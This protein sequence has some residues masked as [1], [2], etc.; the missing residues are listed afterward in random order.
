MLCIFLGSIARADSREMPPW[1]D[2]DDI[3]LA[4]WA[5]SVVPKKSDTPIF[6]APGA[7]DSR[8][9]TAVV[10][11]TLPLYGAKRGASCG[12]R[13]LLVGPLAW[14]CSDAAELSAAEPLRLASPSP[15]ADG[16]PFRY[17]FVGRDG[18]SGF[19]RL[20]GALEDAP[21]QELEPGFAVAVTDVRTMHGESW[22]RTNRGR[23][24][25]LR[26][27]GA[28]HPSAF[29]GEERTD[30]DLAWVIAERA[31]VVRAP[32]AGQAAI[33]TRVRF[34][35]VAWREERPTGSGVMVRVSADG[36]APEE[37]M[38]ARDLAHPTIAEP[39]PE[40]ASDERWIDVELATQTLVAYEGSK[41]VFA[42]LVSTG[43]GGQ[44]SE[45]ATPKGT[46]RIWV[47][48]ATT[49][50]GNLELDET[51]ADAIPMKPQ[52]PGGR[53]S[54][55]DVPYVQFFDKGVGLHAAFWHRDFGHV[56][57]HGCVNLAP[58]DARRL[59]GW[60]LPHLPGGWTAAL[61][62]AVEKGTAVR[63]R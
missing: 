57:S 28:A 41:P 12:G 2:P 19:D 53:Y 59:F 63:V 6:S 37:W 54:I 10:G 49:D 46:H 32:K 47:K 3:P 36:V 51:S 43:R 13:W 35:V 38:R 11:A 25:A 5:K 55:E 23:W 22:G 58:L 34:Q 27:L 33:G 40:V 31:S 9:G 50:M 42:T 30:L 7:I 62:M 26:E 20:E 18:A 60:T 8:R 56:H 39:P 61:P 45:T 4:A 15:L 16:L 1:T 52:E 29:H 14:I 21:A 44:G 17:F 24:V 48:L